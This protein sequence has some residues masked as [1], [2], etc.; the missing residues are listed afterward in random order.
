MVERQL[1]GEIVLDRPVD[2]LD[3]PLEGRAATNRRKSSTISSWVLGQAREP[4]LVAEL[5]DEARFPQEQLRLPGRPKALA[6]VADDGETKPAILAEDSLALFALVVGE[7]AAFA[8]KAHVVDRQRGRNLGKRRAREQ[9]AWDFE[10]LGEKPE[11][12]GAAGL[13]DGEED[14]AEL[15]EDDR[16]QL[17]VTGE[18][19]SRLFAVPGRDL[20][21]GV[22]VSEVP[23]FAQIHVGH[24]APSQSM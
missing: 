3:I 19:G 13:G 24:S 18:P 5:L 8:P 23:L 4:R 7:P 21:V 11:D 6:G 2:I 16:A 14:E 20:S 22:G 15:G 1:A 10:K 17:D 9:V 12:G